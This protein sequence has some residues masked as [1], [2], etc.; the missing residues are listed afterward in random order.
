METLPGQR[1]VH[2]T[3]AGVQSDIFG[4]GISRNRKVVGIVAVGDSAGAIPGMP[5]SPK[6]RHLC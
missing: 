4:R 1:T 2:P 5:G 6:H 3:E